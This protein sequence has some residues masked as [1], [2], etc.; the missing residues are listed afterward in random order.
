MLLRAQIAPY[1]RTTRLILKSHF[2]ALFTA[3]Q[4]NI[5]ALPD[6]NPSWFNDLTEDTREDGR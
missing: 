4:F 1:C 3:A 2:S 6:Y 5:A